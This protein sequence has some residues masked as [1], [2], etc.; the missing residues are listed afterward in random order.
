MA[1]GTEVAEG[2][3]QEVRVL[4]EDEQSEVEH[5]GQDDEGLAKRPFP[6]TTNGS[7]D[8]EVGRGYQRQEPK[9]E[10]AALIIEVIRE[11]RNEEDAQGVRLAQAVIDECE[12]QKQEQKDA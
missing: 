6:H 11:E 4:E 10:S 3:A 5:E 7:G 9:E 2:L 12:R 8:E 1:E